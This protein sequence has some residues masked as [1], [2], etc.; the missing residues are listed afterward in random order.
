MRKKNSHDEN[1]SSMGC[2]RETPEIKR[3]EQKEDKKHGMCKRNSPHKPS[4]IKNKGNTG[5]V[6]ETP[7]IKT[8]QIQMNAA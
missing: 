3:K 1:E 6:R 2:V 4:Q 7:H 5:C 8:S